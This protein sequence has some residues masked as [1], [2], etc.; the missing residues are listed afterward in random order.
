[1]CFHRQVNTFS[2]LGC[3]L[4]YEGGKATEVKVFNFLKITGPTFMW[5][6]KLDSEYKRQ[7]KNYGEWQNTFRW[8]TGETKN[9]LKELK[10]ECLFNKILKYKNNCISAC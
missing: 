6:Q 7:N 5:G 8:P 2:Y 3:P 4:S 10:A 9:I 1:L